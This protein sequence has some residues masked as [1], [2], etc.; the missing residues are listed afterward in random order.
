MLAI[1]SHLSPQRFFASG[2][3]KASNVSNLQLQGLYL[4]VAAINNALV[5]TGVLSRENVDT[6]LRRSEE[7]E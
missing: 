1:A 7:A 3:E 6:A 4:A 2:P 5:S